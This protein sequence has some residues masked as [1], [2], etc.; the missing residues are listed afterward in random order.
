MAP[1]HQVSAAC[2]ARPIQ[3]P[4]SVSLCLRGHGVYLFGVQW[5]SKSALLANHRLQQRVHVVF[6]Q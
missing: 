1:L 5:Q 6:I 2:P 4:V 3:M